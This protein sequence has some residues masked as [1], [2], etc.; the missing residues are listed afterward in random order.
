MNNKNQNFSSIVTVI[1]IGIVAVSAI[2][3]G[4]KEVTK[5]ETIERINNT[6][7]RSVESL[8]IADEQSLGGRVHAIQEQFTEGV[9]IGRTEVGQ[10]GVQQIF[11]DSA[12]TLYIG[13]STDA[14]LQI[15]ANGG[16]TIRDV[17]FTTSSLNYSGSFSADTPTFVVDASNNKVGIGTTTPGTLLELYGNLTGAILAPTITLNSPTT[18]DTDFGIIWEDSS[19]QVFTMFF[20]D[21]ANTLDFAT[22][23][24]ADLLTI[25]YSGGTVT[26]GYDLLVSDNFRATASSTFAISVN[27]GGETQAKRVVQG[28]AVFTTSTNSTGTFLA[29]TICNSA[30]IEVTVTDAA[31]TLTFPST[32]TLHA[33]CLAEIG[34]SIPITIRNVTTTSATA[35]LTIAAGTGIDFQSASTSA[36]LITGGSELKAILQR[37]SDATSTLY[38]FPMIDAD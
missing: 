28:G 21:S 3:F 8:E 20:D 26:V 16:V 30:I 2:L 25:A 7:D 29:S 14:V 9:I 17:T 13:T 1:V 36:D 15:A 23:T 33:D 6:V 34:K 10:T 38:M 27:I 35:T 22:S 19:T 18:T 24:D 12:G 32:S 31:A 4:G 5:I 37:V 11:T